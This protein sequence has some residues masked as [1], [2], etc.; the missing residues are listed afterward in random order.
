M[1]KV[2]VF[3]YAMQYGTL[4][5]VKEMLYSILPIHRKE[6][7]TGT[8]AKTY[9]ALSMAIERADSMFVNLVL[10]ALSIEEQ[11][12][13][14]IQPELGIT[15]LHIAIQKSGNNAEIVKAFKP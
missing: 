10:G 1:K 4:P 3:E 9:N 6:I 2:T 7:I 8:T 5:M 13:V 11:V 12:E 14:I 15:G